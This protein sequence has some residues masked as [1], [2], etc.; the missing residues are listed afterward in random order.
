[1]LFDNPVLYESALRNRRVRALLPTSLSSKELSSIGPEIREVSVVLA[2]VI[3]ARFL[4]AVNDATESAI[5]GQSTE[6]QSRLILK[7]K[8][9]AIGYIP[10]EGQSGRITDLSSD[11]RLNLIMETSVGL[12][13]GFARYFQGQYEGVLNAWPAQE[14][15][16]AL[17]R[18]EPRPWEEIWPEAAAAVDEEALSA[19]QENGIMVARKDSPI[20]VHI[21]DFGLPYSPFKFNS[22]M[23]ER[24]ITRDDAIAYGLIQPKEKVEPAMESFGHKLKVSVKDLDQA[25]QDSLLIGLDDR[26]EIR[27]GVLMRKEDHGN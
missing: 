3:D 26:Y 7:E 14:L 11:H 5:K 17:D 20:W 4:Q 1:M 22:G 25:L 23:R 6:G 15:Y 10:P 27:D 9:K 18:I 8:L 21:S 24:D 13:R 19:Y 16:R 2:H 12:A